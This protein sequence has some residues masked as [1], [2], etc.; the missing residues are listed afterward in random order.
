MSIKKSPSARHFSPKNWMTSRSRGR[1]RGV[2]RSREVI[3]RG[4]GTKGRGTA[5]HRNRLEF[6]EK[7]DTFPDATL[8]RGTGA[9]LYRAHL[10]DEPGESAAISHIGRDRRRA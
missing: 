6:A 3:R 7:E 9:H 2:R 10:R 4:N 5:G 8:G 1:R